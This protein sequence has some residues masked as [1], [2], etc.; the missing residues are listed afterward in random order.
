M[1]DWIQQR[2]KC[3]ETAFDDQYCRAIAE[4]TD[5]MVRQFREGKKLLICGNGGSASD[6]QHIAAEFVGRFQLNREALPAIALSTNTSIL[7]AVGNDYSF[8][9]I[10]SRQVEALGQPGD[11]VWGLSTSGK[12]SNVLHA[13]KRAKD[14]GLITVGMAG[15]QGGLLQEFA[16]YC[17]FVAEKNTPYI[18]EIHLITYHQICEQVEAKLF[19]K[20]GLEAQFAV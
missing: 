3:L 15:N 12:S 16:D 2:L 18:Q 20:A 6:S 19:A 1:S 11:I 13:L 14:M 17:L 8:D 7:T 10:F 4:V 5:L 9:I